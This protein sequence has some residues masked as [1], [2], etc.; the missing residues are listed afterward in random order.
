MT[1]N[2]DA[3]TIEIELS[4]SPTRSIIWLHGLG[5]DGNDFAGIVPQ[6][7]LPEK[8]PIRFIFPHAP[9]QPVS[10][11]GGMQMRSWYDIKSLSFED[12]ADEAGLKE[13]TAT[14][15]AL[16]EQE[17]ARGVA[18]EHILLAG[19]SQGGAV[20]LYT[21]LR[22]HQS[23]AGIMALS[24]YLPLPHKTEAERSN[25]NANIPIF[26][27]HGQ[28][29]PVIPITLA[30]QS[31]EQLQAMGYNVQWHHYPMQHSVSPEEIGDI[32]VFIREA[33]EL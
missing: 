12:R 5:A 18:S 6:L 30:Q 7:G 11:N 25:E 26:M 10:I 20:V 1:N 19:F 33:L 32:T 13:S 9:V 8:A 22:Y 2:S 17:I 23:L 24:T 27:A 16:I 29:D 3:Q 15:K 14:V 31:H 28:H 21:G 4:P